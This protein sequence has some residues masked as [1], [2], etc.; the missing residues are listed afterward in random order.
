[1]KQQEFNTLDNGILQFFNQISYLADRL[2]IW[3]A[4][5]SGKNPFNLKADWLIY[6]RKFGRIYTV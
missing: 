1:M 2:D 4:L 3:S 5:K 6:P